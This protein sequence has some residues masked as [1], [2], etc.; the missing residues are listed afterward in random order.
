MKS[1]LWDTSSM[2]SCIHT[3]FWLVCVG[4]ASSFFVLFFKER[5]AKSKTLLKPYHLFS[6][7]DEGPRVFCHLSN[8]I[9]SEQRL[10]MKHHQPNSGNTTVSAANNTIIHLNFNLFI[11]SSCL[12]ITSSKLLITNTES[13]KATSQICLELQG[14]QIRLVLV[15]I[16]KSKE[17]I[18][19]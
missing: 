11:F 12:I 16:S 5:D 15:H 17:D 3:A 1:V 2:P 8:R 14:L 9:F 4:F 19:H 6:I 13:F 18:V 7:L 10:K